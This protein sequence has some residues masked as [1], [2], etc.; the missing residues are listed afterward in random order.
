MLAFERNGSSKP[1][2]S[3]GARIIAGGGSTN[4]PRVC[5]FGLSVFCL[6]CACVFFSLVSVTSLVAIAGLTRVHTTAYGGS[7]G[8]VRPASVSGGSPAP[9]ERPAS[10]SSGD[11]EL[12]TGGKEKKDKRGVFSLFSR[13]KRPQSHMQ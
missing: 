8:S 2:Y 13:K 4:C 11:S 10:R 1:V 3:E 6:V 5:V 12:S 7:S 9:P